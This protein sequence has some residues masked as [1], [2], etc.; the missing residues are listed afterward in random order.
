[1]VSNRVRKLRAIHAGEDSIRQRDFGELS[2]EIAMKQDLPISQARKITGSI[3]A[4]QIEKFGSVRKHG[5]IF[6]KH[7]Q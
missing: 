3:K 2:H 5:H 7:S 1:M 6:V 4:K